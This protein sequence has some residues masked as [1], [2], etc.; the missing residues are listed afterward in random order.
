VSLDFA[1]S[2]AR[3][4]IEVTNTVRRVLWDIERLQNLERSIKSAEISI[5]EAIDYVERS[6]SKADLHKINKPIR[7]IIRNSLSKN[8]H[9]GASIGTRSWKTSS[10]SKSGAKKEERSL[11]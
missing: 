8:D 1:K 3:T 7:L 5:N 2:S 10:K 6:V 11:E 9:R 4:T